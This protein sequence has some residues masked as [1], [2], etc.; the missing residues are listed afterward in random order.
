MVHLKFRMKVDLQINSSPGGQ[1]PRDLHSATAWFQ[2]ALL[3]GTASHGQ[4][5]MPPEGI[6]RAGQGQ[7]FKC[8]MSA[9]CS[10]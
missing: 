8:L 4:L 7:V 1:H 5:P 3:T 10:G 9:I 6:W 2:H